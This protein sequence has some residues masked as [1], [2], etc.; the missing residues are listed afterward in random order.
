MKLVAGAGVDDSCVSNGVE[1]AVGEGAG[2]AEGFGSSITTGPML[3]SRFTNH[4]VAKTVTRIVA[5]PTRTTMA[6]ATFVLV[7]T[8]ILQADDRYYRSNPRGKSG[9]GVVPSKNQLAPTRSR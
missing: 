2:D 4:R 7:R 3:V 1:Y 5:M 8:L 6:R 9:L